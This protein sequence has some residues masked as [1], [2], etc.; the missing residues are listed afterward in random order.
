MIGNWVQHSDN[1]TIK[2]EFVGTPHKIDIQSFNFLSFY[3]QI[4]ITS[5]LLLK[6]GFVVNDNHSFWRL[7]QTS[8][9][10]IV[11]ELDGGFSIVYDNKE[12]RKYFACEDDMYSWQGNEIKSLHQLQN[13][14]FALTQT[15]LQINL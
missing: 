15:E 13:L 6:C 4:P 10:A 1:N 12:F 11:Y 2:K 5:E 9:T 8:N 3:N 14:I 7:N